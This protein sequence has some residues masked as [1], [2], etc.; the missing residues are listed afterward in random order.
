MGAMAFVLWACIL[1]QSLDRLP[2]RT[3]ALRALP[4]ARNDQ[5]ARRTALI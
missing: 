5:P 1:S 2:M 3:D 4:C